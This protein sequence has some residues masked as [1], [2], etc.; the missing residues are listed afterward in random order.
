MVVPGNWS[1]YL[2]HTC[3]GHVPMCTSK[4]LWHGGSQ[5]ILFWHRKLYR[6]SGVR[7][8]SLVTPYVIDTSINMRVTKIFLNHSAHFDIDGHISIAILVLPNWQHW[9]PSRST[10][11]SLLGPS[12]WRATLFLQLLP[13]FM[14]RHWR[15]PGTFR[16]HI[17]P[18]GSW[19]IN[20]FIADLQHV[21]TVTGK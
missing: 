12:W 1:S 21:T 14:A 18:V 6:R 7:W 11:L 9:V 16:D 13:S 10:G 19:L 2:H 20:L 3:I 4:Q 8:A 5:E 17:L 15:R